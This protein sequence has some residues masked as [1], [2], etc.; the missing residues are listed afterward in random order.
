MIIFL[1]IISIIINIF[2]IKKKGIDIIDYINALDDI[3][4]FNNECPYAHHPEI[5]YI[6]ENLTEDLVQD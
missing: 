4:R 3:Y 6:I 5:K 2:M 1:L